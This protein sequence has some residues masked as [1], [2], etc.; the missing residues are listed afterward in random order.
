VV[1]NPGATLSEVEIIESVKTRLAR[2]K[3]P[4][5][6]L[7]VDELPRNTMGKVQKNALR[8]AFAKIYL[9]QSN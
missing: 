9:S 5:R 4:K 2:Y 3:V 1:A 6:V 7:L 8:Q